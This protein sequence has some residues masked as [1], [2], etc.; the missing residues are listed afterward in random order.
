VLSACHRRRIERFVVE[1]AHCK[2]GCLPPLHFQLPLV[3]VAERLYG[4]GAVYLRLELT[5]AAAGQLLKTA[6]VRAAAIAVLID[7]QPILLRNS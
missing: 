5:A 7:N 1:V 6:Q 3:E 2:H 4:N